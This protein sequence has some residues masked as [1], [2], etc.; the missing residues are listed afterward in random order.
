[1]ILPFTL[2][3]AETVQWY[4]AAAG[5]AWRVHS[6]FSHIP[7]SLIGM[8]GWLTGLAPLLLHVVSRYLHVIFLAEQ[9]LRV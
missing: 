4:S 3:L 7:G 9:P 5:L 1:M 2:V 6:G 8:P